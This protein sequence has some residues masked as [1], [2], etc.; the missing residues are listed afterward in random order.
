[1]LPRTY[2]AQNCSL[3]RALEIVGERWTLLILRDVFL[4][5]RRF[6]DFQERL[7][8]SRTVLAGRL[9]RLVEEGIL[10][11]ERYQERPDRYEYV[12]TQK[13]R[14]LWPA[15]NA[16]RA[17][18]DVYETPRRAATAVRPRAV[19][20]ADRGRRVLPALRGRRPSGGRSH[21]S[22]PRISAS[23]RKQA[24]PVAQ[25]THLLEP[26]VC[27][28]C[29]RRRARMAHVPATVIVGA[30]WGDEGK[31][32]IVDLLAQDSDLVCRYQGGPNAGHTIVVEGETYK[33]RAV[34]S[35]II[36]GKACA[37]GAGCVVDPQVL[38]GELDDLESRGHA[39]AGLVFVSGN[40]HLIM[41]WHVA[42]DGA[43]ER[44]LGNLQI[45]TTRRGIGP[46][47]ADKAT[48]IGIRVQ[49]L[50]DPKILHQKIEL[51]VTEKNVWLERVYEIDPFDAEEVQHTYEGYAQRLRPYIADTSLLVDRALRNGDNV[52]FEGAQG[53]LL[54]LDHGTYPF[55]TSSSPIAAGAAV[56]LRH[57]PE[58]HRRDPRR[59]EGVR[60]ARRRRPVPVRDPGRGAAA[61]ARARRRV[62]NRDRPGAALR[63]AR[64]AGVALRGARQR[65]HLT[66]AHEAGRALDLRRDPRL[67]AVLL[68]DGSETDDFPAHQSDFHH[69]RPVWETLPGWEQELDSASSPTQPRL[70][71]LRRG[72]PRRPRLARRHGAGPRGRAD[73][74][75]ALAHYARATNAAATPRR[76]SRGTGTTHASAPTSPR[77]TAS[78]QRAWRAKPRS[79]DSTEL[80][81]G[82]G[83]ARLTMCPSGEQV[84]PP[85]VGE[86]DG[87]D[88]VGCG[89]G[90]MAAVIP[91]ASISHGKWPALRGSRRPC[92]SGRSAAVIDALRRR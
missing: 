36:T 64:P 46:A 66:R 9:H 7:D 6:D 87:L 45:G 56:E 81:S 77:A 1:M 50:L 58:P 76:S 72:R 92:S 28:A 26:S 29:R 12:L 89:R 91:A 18:G 31:G 35:G 32:K 41:P 85:P 51:A 63:L 19:R 5:V 27:T 65:H 88:A 44:K 17:W 22:R 52:L 53:T 15:I 8:V 60:D 13:G 43:R 86:R 73:A 68:P 16:L 82:R 61:R 24:A 42:L 62:R 90:S 10:A 3:A 23:D 40:A 20:N 83:P 38:I 67:R 75:L 14:D 84:D 25:P 80:P 71:P 55:V 70:R 78:R 69:C 11:R 48:R 34:P 2:D 33:I 74:A 57:R 54:D 49:D 59:L 37:I 30:Q 47:Y 21:E 79:I 39:T 4:G